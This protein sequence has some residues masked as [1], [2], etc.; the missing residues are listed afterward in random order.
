MARRSIVSRLVLSVGL[1]AVSAACGGGGGGGEPP[2]V[3]APVGIDLNASE[4]RALSPV[5]ISASALPSELEVDDVVRFQITARVR[6]PA[7]LERITIAL[8]NPP[9][10]CVVPTAT[11]TGGTFAAR[12]RWIV[13]AA[14][15]GPLR[16]SFRVIARRGVFRRSFDVRVQPR[17]SCPRPST[18]ARHPHRRRTGDGLSTGQFPRPTAPTTAGPL[19]VRGLDDATTTPTATLRDPSGSAGDR[20]A[21][22]SRPRRS[23]S[24]VPLV[25]PST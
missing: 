7:P 11:G 8:Q 14:S 22:R 5:T 4:E 17:P 24:L 9:P 2:F 25:H 21:S 19:R 20:L 15:C 18:A 12:G 1:A 13:N 23:S 10:G 16:L 6:A 3:V